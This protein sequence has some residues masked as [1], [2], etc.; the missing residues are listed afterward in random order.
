MQA[1]ALHCLLVVI[2]LGTA[3]AGAGA[4]TLTWDGEIDS[5]WYNPANWDPDAYPADG[6]IRIISSGTPIAS[7][8][9]R[10][11]NGGAILVTSPASATFEADLYVAD[12][13]TGTLN[14]MAGGN[15]SDGNAC[16]GWGSG[17]TGTATVEDSG[18]TWTNNGDLRV[19][20]YG[21]GTLEVLAGGYVKNAT[22]WIA[23]EENSE[24]LVTV[25][26]SGST[27]ESTG[28]LEVGYGG[29]GTLTIAGGG[30]VE[31][32]NGHIGGLAG[33]QGTVTV[34]DPCSTWTNGGEL[35]VGYGGSGT[36]DIAGG[37]GRLEHVWPDRSRRLL[38]RDGHGGRQRLDVD[39]QPEPLGR[40]QRHR[41]AGHHQRRGR[42]ER[43][44]LRRPLRRLQRGGH[45]GRQR[46]DVDQQR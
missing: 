2:L 1:G 4:Q 26:G 25:D 37:G 44:R 19:G 35:N 32:D 38:E 20:N 42:L 43:D 39:E 40:R 8:D 31:D 24:G 28:D 14:I 23:Y 18:S 46:L 9:V 21:S 11:S 45:G 16:I 17:S 29:S 27:W 7:T 13:N 15:V 34:S 6:D 33:S 30:R 3:L 12:A 10:A 5:N 36:L 41:Q 22:A